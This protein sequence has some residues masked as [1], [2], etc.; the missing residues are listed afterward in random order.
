MISRPLQ[1]AKA[2]PASG[3]HTRRTPAYR[4]AGIVAMAS[5]PSRFTRGAFSSIGS[6]LLAL[7]ASASR[8]FLSSRFTSS[9][10][11]Q[12]ALVNVCMSS[13]S[14]IIDE[15][16]GSNSGKIRKHDGA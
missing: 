7:E 12:P 15:D 8:L 2:R 16:G 13:P 9:R 14:F 6:A 3:G 10:A 11:C 4:R 1:S 5:I